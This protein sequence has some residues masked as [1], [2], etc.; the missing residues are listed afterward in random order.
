MILNSTFDNFGLC[1]RNDNYLIES[2]ASD[3][4]C[5]FD[6]SELFEVRTRSGLFGDATVSR[7]LWHVTG[8][9]ICYYVKK[10]RHSSHLTTFISLNGHPNNPNNS[11]ATSS[12]A[13]RTGTQA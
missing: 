12:A 1:W 8:A 6:P 3:F 5:S 13:K 9:S 10:F 7:E 4:G 11:S 2:I